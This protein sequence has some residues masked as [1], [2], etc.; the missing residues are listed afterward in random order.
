MATPLS[1]KWHCVEPDAQ[2]VEKLA[3]EA[4]IPVS[5]AQ[6]FAANGM[7]RAEQVRDF[8]HSGLQ[9]L[10]QPF[11]LK[12]MEKAVNLIVAGLERNALFI[13]YGDYDVDGV[14]ATAV[15]A[16]FLQEVGARVKTV[17]PNRKIHG[18]GLHAGL[19]EQLAEEAAGDTKGAILVTVDCGI[20][21][22]D[23][24]A[25]ARELG[26][27]TIITDHHRLPDRLPEA[28]AVINP[29]QDGCVFP[30]KD[31]AGVGL[32]FYLTAG[33]RSAMRKKNLFSNGKE[34]NLKEYLDLVAIGTVCDM[35]PLHGTNRILVRTGSEVIE[36]TRRHG[37]KSLLR[38]SNIDGGS[39]VG[40]ENIAFRLGPRINAAGRLDDARLAYS[41]LVSRQAEEAAGLADALNALNEERKRITE[42][43]YVSCCAL[44]EKNLKDYKYS[45]VLT[46]KNWHQGVLGIV[47]SKLVQEYG[48]P[49]VLLTETRGENGLVLLKGSARSVE[50]FDLFAALTEC[51]DLLEKFGGHEQAAGLTVQ[52]ENI[53]ALANRLEGIAANILSGKSGPEKLRVFSLQDLTG[54]ERDS[55]LNY[56]RAMEPFG[57]GNP[58]PVFVVEGCELRELQ[59][60]GDGHLRFVL[61]KD[62]RRLFPGIGFN[63]GELKN[64]L[65]NRKIDLAFALRSNRF[66]GVEQWQVNFVDYDDAATH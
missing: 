16:V 57:V 3:R 20:S 55:F 4:D 28:D 60:V 13:I 65:T 18:Y 51:T 37:L 6:I 54:N 27:I 47:A 32:S 64:L 45:L 14:T 61:F 10:P 41:L 39:R 34:P 29:L 46:G 66:R 24:I 33:I 9:Q 5:I 31:L 19:L 35:A 1:K 59:I 43:I 36:Q 50:G 58:E 63:R 30:D 48:L 17:L 40:C 53:A 22:V 7:S 52:E 8:L 38:I 42:D 25:L 23:E 11:L 12:D 44:A 2:I 15:L 56:Y 62:N 26:F 49:T 21:N